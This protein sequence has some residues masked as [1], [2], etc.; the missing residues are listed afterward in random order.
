M[1]WIEWEALQFDFHI[2]LGRQAYLYFTFFVKVLPT[3]FLWLYVVLLFKVCEHGKIWSYAEKKM[4][5]HPAPPIDVQYFE[6]RADPAVGTV[7]L[8]KL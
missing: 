7:M 8:R 4:P 3:C 5:Y 1:K 6:P 2:T